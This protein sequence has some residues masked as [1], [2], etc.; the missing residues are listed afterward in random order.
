MDSGRIL[1]G[2]YRK[3][4]DLVSSDAIVHMLRFW[5]E[6]LEVSSCLGLGIILYFLRCNVSWSVK[7]VVI[8]LKIVTILYM[9][10][11]R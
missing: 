8:I 9:L 10:F 7:L 3:F 1:N 11:G 6:V 2:G 5:F 4:D